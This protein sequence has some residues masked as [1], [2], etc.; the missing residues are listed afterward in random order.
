MWLETPMPPLALAEVVSRPSPVFCYIHLGPSSLPR[1][2]FDSIYQTQ[3]WN[4]QTRVYVA[5]D[6]VHA[7]TFEAALA[8]TRIE[9]D[10]VF[11]VFTNTLRPT[12]DHGAF[13]ANHAFDDRFRLGF[14]R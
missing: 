13:R 11:L 1:C 6:Q 12:D 14:Y 10:T 5:L 9:R 2:L 7:S 8:A 4:P 3:A